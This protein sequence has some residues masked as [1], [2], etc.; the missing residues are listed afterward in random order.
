MGMVYETFD[1]LFAFYQQ[2]LASAVDRA[3]GSVAFLR[4][5]LPK[6]QVETWPELAKQGLSGLM[7]GTCQQV[8]LNEEDYPR[9]F[10]RINEAWGFVKI[11]CSATL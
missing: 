1:L 5:F 7:N 2:F 6:R 9:V 11:W 3:L 8:G 4:W 10:E